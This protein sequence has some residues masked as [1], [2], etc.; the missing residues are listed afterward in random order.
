MDQ[1]IKDYADHVGTHF[2]V[3]G[4]SAL[5]DRVRAAA[6]SHGVHN[7]RVHFESFGPAWKS[8]DGPVRLSLSESGMD[9]EVPVGTTL[10]E[11]MEAAGAWMASDCK[12]GECGACIATYTSGQ[13]LHRDNCLT[14]EQREHSFCPCVSWATSSD[15]L[16]LQL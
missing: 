13:P 15:V 16:T 5:I 9:L 11:A 14:N 1:L 2:Y 7:R 10:L 4:P 12:R 8:S 6:N 3:C